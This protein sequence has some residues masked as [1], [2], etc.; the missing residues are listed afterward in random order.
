M[1]AT[2]GRGAAGIGSGFVT[3]NGIHNTCGNIRITGGQVTATGGD[4]GDHVYPDIIDNTSWENF[5][6]YGEMYYK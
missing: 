3:Y 4:G 5:T 2:G 1:N 6:Y